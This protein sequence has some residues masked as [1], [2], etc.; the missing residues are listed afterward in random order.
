MTTFQI[1]VRIFV[2]NKK[3]HLVLAYQTAIEKNET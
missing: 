3:C 2:G 1:G